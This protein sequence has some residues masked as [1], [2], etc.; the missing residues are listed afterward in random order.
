MLNNDFDILWKVRKNTA[1]TRGTICRS[2]T[3]PFSRDTW[4]GP[5]KNILGVIYCITF[6]TIAQRGT[7]K[8]FYLEHETIRQ[9]T[10]AILIWRSAI[11]NLP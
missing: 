11:A 2:F 5:L 4:K 8:T 1:P 3:S 7:I 9:K 6:L 10:S